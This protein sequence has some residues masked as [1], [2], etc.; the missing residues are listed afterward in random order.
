MDKEEKIDWENNS[1]S[2]IQ[3][4]LVELGYV[5]ESLK[6]KMIKLSEQL[7]EIEK[8]YIL[9]NNTLNKRLRGL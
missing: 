7:E 2:T 8:E 5:H 6:T 9:G 3:H 1:N 4:K